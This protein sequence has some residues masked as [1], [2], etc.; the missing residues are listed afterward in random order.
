M[1][2]GGTWN[3]DGVILFSSSGGPLQRVEATGG[4]CTPVTKTGS[5]IFYP[6]FLPDG[7]HFLYYLGGRIDE[8]KKGVYLGT[9]DNPIGRRLLTDRSGVV[10]APPA[11]GIGNGH[12]LFLRETTL[13][14]QPFDARTLQLA[15]DA[16]PVA[17]QA[18]ANSNRVQVAASASRNGVLVYLANSTRDYQLTWFDRTGKE[19]AKVGSHGELPTVSLSPDEKIVAFGR[20]PGAL[21]LHELI[22]GVDTQFTFPPLGSNGAVWSPDG[23]RIAFGS[24]KRRPLSQGREWRRPGGASSAERQPQVSFRLVLRWTV[25]PVH[26]VDPK[27]RDDLWILPDPLGKSGGGTPV[28]FLR[29]EFS[30]SHGQFSPDGRWVAYVSDQSG[31]FEVYVRPFPSGAGQVKVSSNGGREPRWRRDGKELFY[32]EPDGLMHRL[33]TVPIQAGSGPLFAAG[34]TKP[35]FVFRVP[36]YLTRFNSFP[37][38]VAAGG[39]RFLA[40]TSLSTAEPTL[41]VIL[42]WE[43]AAAVK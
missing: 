21:W 29:T 40:S 16:F 10:F 15:G 17:G 11:S 3:S 13:M 43:K 5:T 24:P 25:P 1:I 26:G 14:A 37:Y 12:I 19:Q 34:A 31:Q 39:Q 7:K 32:L 22:R 20:P 27:T 23:G 18:S 2:G 9:L 36:T 41:N 28:P 4:A 8:A 6:V 42:N 35:L 38:S 33:M 30:E